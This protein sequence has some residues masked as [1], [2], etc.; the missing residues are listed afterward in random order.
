MNADHVAL[1]ERLYA[2]FAKGDVPTVLAALDSRV[3]WNEA[4]GY[5]YADGN[6]Y[7]GPE[8]VLQGVFARLGQEWDDFRVH[9]HSAVPTPDGAV[10]FGR[11]AGA[12][13]A[14]GRRLDAPFAHVWTLKDGKVVAFQ[15]Y[16]DTAQFVRIMTQ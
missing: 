15:Q 10:S 9:L 4:E 11:Y 2:A 12:F 16:T 13:K 5:A 3:E 1:V 7:V 14:T 8:A 6:P